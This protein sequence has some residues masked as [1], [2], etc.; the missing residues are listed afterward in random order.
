MN[1]RSH[2]SYRGPLQ[3][4]VL[5]W[6]GTAVDYGSF[7]PTSVFLRLFESQ[8]VPIT[9]ED[10]RSGM[11]LMKKDHLRTILAR[12][13]VAETWQ[14]VHGALASEADINNLFDNFVPLQLDVL[15]DYAEPIPGVLNTLK[16]LRQQGLKI[17]STTGYLRSMMDI[18]APEAA[19]RGY[20]PDC[21]ICPDE[22]PAGR[23]YPW[24]CY[25]NAIRLGVYPMQAMVKIGDSLADI[26]EGLNAG[27]WTIGLSL[28]G[29]MLGL[30][31]AEVGALP[32]DVLT[33]KRQAISEQMMQTGAH[34]VIDGLWDCLP[35]IEAINT[36]L[37]A[38]ECP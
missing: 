9:P 22:V 7:A 32:A 31:E 10:A 20:A 4:L 35:I 28:S 3:A 38:G 5:D 2:R 16:M 37:A 15:K 23:P 1:Q 33:A 25:Q 30:R 11:G 21:T 14:A 12:P 26:E 19:Q 6:A 8:N 24:M 36:R 27:M 34:Y 17:G 13:S 29:N 18:L